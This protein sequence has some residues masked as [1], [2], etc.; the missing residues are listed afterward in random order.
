MLRSLNFEAF[1]QRPIYLV[2]INEN[3]ITMRNGTVMSLN[4]RGIVSVQEHLRRLK[5]DPNVKVIY[6]NAFEGPKI[7][8][9]YFSKS[10]KRIF[11]RAFYGSDLRSI[12]FEEGTDIEFFGDE[13]FGY[14]MIT[15][16]NLT[17]KGKMYKYSSGEDIVIEL[18]PNFSPE[19]LDSFIYIDNSFIRIYCSRS[20]I[21]TLARH[22]QR[23]IYY[24]H[25]NEDQ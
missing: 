12:S 7:R 13:V 16:K 22:Y 20:S 19:Q 15:A 4:P 24:F 11:S 10:L 17:I 9:L 23:G 25:I 18:P 3:S 6:S 2:F 1:V 5:I 8:R 21:R 14:S